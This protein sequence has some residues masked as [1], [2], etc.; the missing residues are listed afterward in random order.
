MH[1][2]FFILLMTQLSYDFSIT[3]ITGNVILILEMKV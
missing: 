3:D 2:V 1:V